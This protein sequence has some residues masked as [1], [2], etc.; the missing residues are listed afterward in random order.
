MTFPSPKLITGVVTL[1]RGDTGYGIMYIKTYLVS[2]SLDGIT[3]NV[4]DNGRIFIGNNNHT[5]KV[6]NDIKQRFLASAVRI[7]PLTW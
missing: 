3:W 4:A 6:T 7:L 2:Y 1:G 5:S